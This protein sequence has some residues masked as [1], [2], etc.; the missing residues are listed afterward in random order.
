M[1]I[2]KKNPDAK[3]DRCFVV[4]QF[5]GLLIIAQRVLNGGFDGLLGLSHLRL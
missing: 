2:E 4:R 5:Q 3:V 1:K